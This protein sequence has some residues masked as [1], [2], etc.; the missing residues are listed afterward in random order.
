MK[1][2]DQSHLSEDYLTPPKR[3]LTAEEVR[4]LME[5]I[6]AD[7][8]D[9]ADVK[10]ARNEIV[11]ANH[12]LVI[13]IARRFSHCDVPQEDLVQE[14]CLGLFRAI[15]KFD[16]NRGIA[17]STYA[18]WWVKQYIGRHIRTRERPIVLPQWQE[19]LLA[20]VK[21]LEREITART[22]RIPSVLELASAIEVS[23]ETLAQLTLS[24][25]PPT[26]LEGGDSEEGRP[27]TDRIPGPGES[28]ETSYLRNER[29]LQILACLETLDSRSLAII[30]ARYGID[31]SDEA[32]ET[33]VAIGLT[34]EISRER[35]RQIE[36]KALIALGR[37]LKKVGIASASGD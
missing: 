16:P 15:E 4:T 30:K 13:L 10:K 20:Q 11:E 25:A 34:Q 26:S 29:R 3:R 21:I 31:K 8:A 23:P 7:E 5:R 28:A 9:E 6:R 12:R 2:A 22:G 17:F 18:T 36:I 19:R 35:V 37:K 1:T 33:L 14:G 27:L 24:A 32:K